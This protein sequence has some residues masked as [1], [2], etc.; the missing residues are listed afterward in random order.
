V[1][2]DVLSKSGGRNGPD[3]S[4]LE[5]RPRRRALE[6]RRTLGQ[7][8]A[9]AAAKATQRSLA[10]VAA[11]RPLRSRQKRDGIMAANLEPG[12]GHVDADMYGWT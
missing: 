4:P 9:A 3:R 8:A 2:Y 10:A 6:G 7:L 11:G 12:D 1:A 5:R